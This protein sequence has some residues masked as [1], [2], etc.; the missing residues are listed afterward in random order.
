MEKEA[1]EYCNPCSSDSCMGSNGCLQIQFH[2]SPFMAGHRPSHLPLPLGIH[3]SLLEKVKS[4]PSYLSPSFPSDFIY[5][6]LSNICRETPDL[7]EL[8]ISEEGAREQAQMLRRAAE[9]GIRLMF[10]V[11]CER[12][13]FVFA[14]VVASLY[15]ISLAP[16]YFDFVTLCYIG[17]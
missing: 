8:E 2:H 3:P 9:E 13:W 10:H 1:T 11:S 5:H 6:F 14:G 17:I 15:L 12:E 16:K 4:K 7:S